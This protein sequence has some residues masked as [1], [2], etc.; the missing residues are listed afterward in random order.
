MALQGS[1]PIRFSQITNEFG[2]TNSNRF[3][4]YRVSESVG[5]L[6][7]LPLDTGIPQSGQIRFSDFYSKK[8]NVVVDC[9]SS[10]LSNSTRLNG[11]TRYIN[12]NVTVIGG[13]KNRPLNSSGTKVYINANV[14][15]GSVQSNDTRYVAL[16]TGNW[17]SGTTLNVEIGPSGQLFGAGGNGG[18]GA[19][20]SGNGYPGDS[21]TSALGIEYSGTNVVN[22]GYIQCGFGGGGGGGGGYADPD[23]NT[24]TDSVVG[25]SGGGG[26]A[27]F[28]SGS[29]GIALVGGGYGAGGPGNNGSAA[30]R[31]VRGAGGGSNFGPGNSGGA[32]GYGGDGSVGTAAAGG[33]GGGNLASGAGGAAGG[34]GYA[35]VSSVG[36]SYTITNLGTIYGGTIYN[37]VL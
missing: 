16:R 30:T 3:G 31:T 28:P 8:L 19:A 37:S 33:S 23:K 21:G 13:F 22:R 15:I 25:G 5:S 26:G 4:L 14:D 1:G 10:S 11:R 2:V 32:G 24:G 7:N 18:N 6:S 9:Y 36:A 27:G 17:D 29:G 20:G 12:N 35:V 34:N